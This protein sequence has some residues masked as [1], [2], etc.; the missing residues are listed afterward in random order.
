MYDGT[1]T[2]FNFHEG[3]GKWYLSVISGV[4]IGGAQASSSSKQG[5]VNGDSVVAL[6]P[7]KPG[8]AILTGAGE[9][10]YT[11]PKEYA[12][13]SDPENRI[14]F[15]P[16]TDFIYEGAWDDLTPISD[17]AYDSG[18]YHEMNDVLD[19]VHLIASAEYFG[20][21]PHFEIGGR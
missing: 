14:T 20:L 5:R 1:I 2:L 12:A 19:G 10:S 9:K 8:K 3:T 15:K 16:E 21:I 11:A 18:L 17:D 13:C 6:I 7:C 4:D